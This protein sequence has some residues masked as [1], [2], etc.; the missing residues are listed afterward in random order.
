MSEQRE[1]SSDELTKL[2]TNFLSPYCFPLSLYSLL[3][4]QNSLLLSPYS[5]LIC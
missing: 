4:S 3:I 5:L 2:L 1:A